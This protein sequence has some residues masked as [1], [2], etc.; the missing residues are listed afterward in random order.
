VGKHRRISAA[1][2]S[3]CTADAG[4]RDWSQTGRGAR[5]FRAAPLGPC[6]SATTPSPVALA[7]VPARDPTRVAPSRVSQSATPIAASVKARCTTSGA[8]R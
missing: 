8:E 1:R 5:S 2:S 7:E 3:P 4:E 6:P